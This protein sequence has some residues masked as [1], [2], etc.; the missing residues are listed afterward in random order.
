MRSRGL[1]LGSV[2]VACL[3]SVGVASA[4]KRVTRPFVI[5]VE[6]QFVVM[7]STGWT[8]GDG[9]GVATHLGTLTTHGE[10][11]M[12][13]VMPGTVTAANGDILCF[14]WNPLTTVVTFTGGTGRFVGATGGFTMTITPLGPPQPGPAP[15]TVV[16]NLAWTGV[17]T[18]TY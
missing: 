15:G 8:T 13:Q 14:D 17:G 5:A 10:G 9:V 1:V 12:G 18:I 11:P 4:Q 2:L 16:Q 7:M 6:S 3:S